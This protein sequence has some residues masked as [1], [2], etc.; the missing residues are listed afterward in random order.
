MLREQFCCLSSLLSSERNYCL[1]S[2]AFSS[3]RPSLCRLCVAALSVNSFCGSREA[4]YGVF[5]GDRNV[6][7]PYLL[8]CTMNDVLAEEIHKTKSEEDY[9]TNTFL[10]MQRYATASISLLSQII[11]ILV[12]NGFFFFFTIL[13]NLELQDRN[14]AAQR[15]FVTSATTRPIPEAASH[16]LLLMWASARPSCAVMGNR[17]QCRCFTI[18]GLRRSTGGSGSTGPSL[19]R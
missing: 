5:D 12:L 16:S 2:A 1:F 19:Q 8:Q 4:L 6:E 3:L 18:S 9:M 15:L 13:E 17:C 14:W 11:L 7:V 10:V